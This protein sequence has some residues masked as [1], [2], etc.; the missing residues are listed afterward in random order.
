AIAT[1]NVLL[2]ENLPQ[3][4]AEKGEYMLR[5]INALA[6]RYPKVLKECRGRGLMLGMEFV[7]NELGYAV[8]KALFARQILISG[9]YINSKVLR[10]EP[11]LVIP[12]EQIDRFHRALEESLQQV[13]RDFHL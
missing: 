8:A 2:E 5:H 7:N 9:T 11:P 1:I 6:A 10:I 13:H 3:Q 12:Y 4:A